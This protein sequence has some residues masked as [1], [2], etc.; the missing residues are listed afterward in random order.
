MGLAEATSAPFGQ[1]FFGTF[2]QFLAVLG[3]FEAIWGGPNPRRKKQLMV[4]WI[5][6]GFTVEPL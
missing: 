2:S 5:Q 3:E 4:R 6:E 1:I